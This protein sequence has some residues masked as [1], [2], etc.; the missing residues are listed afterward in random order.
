MV[1]P[2]YFVAAPQ[3]TITFSL[4][5]DWP[6]FVGVLASPKTFLFHLFLSVIVLPTFEALFAY[7]ANIVCSFK[8]RLFTYLPICNLF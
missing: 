2:Q 4:I 7:F 8:K 5:M 1:A 3:Y 6:F